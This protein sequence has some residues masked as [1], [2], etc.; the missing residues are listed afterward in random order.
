MKT[1]RTKLVAAFAVL[2]MAATAS[3]FA[4]GKWFVGKTLKFD[5]GEGYKTSITLYDNGSVVFT[6][7]SGEQLR[8]SYTIDEAKKTITCKYPEEKM[9]YEYTDMFL[10]GNDGELFHSDS[11]KFDAK[12][13]KFLF[14]KKFDVGGGYILEFSNDGKVLYNGEKMYSYVVDES[15]KYIVWYTLKAEAPLPPISYEVDKKGKVTLITKSES[16]KEASKV[17]GFLNKLTK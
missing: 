14:G 13:A 2:M 1:Q 12:S 9:E 10:F 5:D 8:G 17:G 11:A 15:A 6:Y 16:I 7:N 4:E 3:L